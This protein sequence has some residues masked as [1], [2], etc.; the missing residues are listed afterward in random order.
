MDPGVF[1]SFPVPVLDVHIKVSNNQLSAYTQIPAACSKQR[2]SQFFLLLEMYDVR[3][4]RQKPHPP[5]V[6]VQNKWFDLFLFVSV[7]RKLV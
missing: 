3:E 2:L 7:R 4:G 1:S 6:Q 5:P